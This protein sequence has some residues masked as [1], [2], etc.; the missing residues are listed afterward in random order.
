MSDTDILPALERALRLWQRGLNVF[1]VPPPRPGV[2][3][4]TPG[5]GK[6]PIL[7]WGPLQTER[8]T[9]ANLRDWFRTEQNIAIVMG[10]VSGV[11]AIDADSTEGM[12]WVTRHLPYTPWQTKTAR[13]YHLFYR[14]PG[15]RVG[16]KVQLN[17]GDGKLPIDVRGD[18]GYVIGPGSRHASGHVYTEAGD[19]SVPRKSLPV[20]SLSWLPVERPTPA[21]AQMSTARTFGPSDPV[22]RARKYLAAIPR[23]EIGAGSDAATL[24]AACRIVRGFDLSEADAT[25]LLWEWAGGR[26]GWTFGWVAQ[27]VQHAIRYGTEPIGALR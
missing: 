11:V 21:R 18:G 12:Q 9:D 2:P 19:W 8:V 20:F 4:N 7:T 25:T 1:P 17:T 5:D 26:S 14:H 15:E 16:N 10:A 13:A 22:E 23:P 3:K 24:Y 6:T 27:K